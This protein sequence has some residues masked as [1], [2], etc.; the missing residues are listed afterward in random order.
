MA[1]PSRGIVAVLSSLD[2][3]VAHAVLKAGNGSMYACLILQ[4]MLCHQLE[5]RC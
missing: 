2:V 5:E 4:H 1:L 3:L